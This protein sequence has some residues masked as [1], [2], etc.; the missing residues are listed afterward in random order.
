MNKCTLKQMISLLNSAFQH[1]R[2][3]NWLRIK[4]NIKI[5]FLLNTSRIILRSP[6]YVIPMP[7]FIYI[8][9]PNVLTYTKLKI[10]LCYTVS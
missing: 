9:N 5:A 4:I 1:M 3:S 6:L 10:K 7:S 2:R 8:L